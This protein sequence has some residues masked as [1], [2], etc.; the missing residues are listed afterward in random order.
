MR[1]WSWFV[2]LKVVG[3]CGFGF[4]LEG[5][6][7]GERKKEKRKEKKKMKKRKIR[8]EK[9]TLSTLPRSTPSHL[10]HAQDEKHVRRERLDGD[11]FDGRVGANG[12]TL[13]YLWC[14]FPRKKKKR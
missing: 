2:G 5:A 10:D 7:R 14:F 8:K 6:G 4:V 11:G 9:K 13:F 3:F 1:W 12:S